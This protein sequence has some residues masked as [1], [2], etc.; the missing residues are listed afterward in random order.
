MNRDQKWIVTKFLESLTGMKLK[1]TEP[2]HKVDYRLQLAEMVL[3]EL[4]G[5]DIEELA[6]R[7]NAE[8][9]RDFYLMPDPERHER[10]ERAM[11]AYVDTLE[12][13]ESEN[14]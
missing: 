12:S 9:V 8:A 2:A 3:T 6:H 5:N 13:L 7:G 1:E 11:R 4:P 10:F 14:D